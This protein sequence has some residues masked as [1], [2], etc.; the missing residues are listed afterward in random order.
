MLLAANHNI[1][2]WGTIYAETGVTTNEAMKLE[3][4]KET[5]CWNLRSKTHCWITHRRLIWLTEELKRTP[6]LKITQNPWV[7]V[8]ET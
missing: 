7:D 4:P 5:D 1:R 6:Y 3:L 8:D 2:I